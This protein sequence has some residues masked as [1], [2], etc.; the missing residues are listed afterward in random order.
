MCFQ[1]IIE[2][3]TTTTL[4]CPSNERGEMRRSKALLLL[5]SNCCNYSFR[6]CDEWLLLHVHRNTA[7]FAK[8]RTQAKNGIAD[9]QPVHRVRPAVYDNILS[10][11]MGMVDLVGHHH[12]Q[13]SQ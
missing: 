7:L 3:N 2:L 6:Y 12:G 4:R 11:R 5:F 1:I 9:Y 8:G 10:G 13:T